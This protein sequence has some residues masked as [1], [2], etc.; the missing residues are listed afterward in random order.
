MFKHIPNILTIIRF[1]LI[2]V[3]II[4]AVKDNYVA[5]IIVLSVSGIT[6]ILDGFIA[7]KYNFIT[8]FGFSQFFVFLLLLI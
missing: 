3:I 4:F 7:R 8:D 5:T 2:P 1:L 6:D